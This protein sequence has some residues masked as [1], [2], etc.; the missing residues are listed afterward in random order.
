MPFK[1]L[2]TIHYNL[3]PASAGY[4]AS[5]AHLI[6]KG[7]NSPTVS[8]NPYAKRVE[9]R[10]AFEGAAHSNWKSVKIYTNHNGDYT[11]WYSSMDWTNPGNSTGKKGGG[12][13]HGHDRLFSKDLNQRFTVTIN[14]S[15]EH[16][17]THCFCADDVW[18]KDDD[19]GT[20]SVSL[21][22]D[23]LAIPQVMGFSVRYSAQGSNSN[24][25]TGGLLHRV[26]LLFVERSK[27]KGGADDNYKYKNNVI[28]L[29]PSKS[30]G[31]YQL[32]NNENNITD[33]WK[34]ISYIWSDS[35]WAT[36]QSKFNPND[37]T[38]SLLCIGVMIGGYFSPKMT[39]IVT[40]TMH[41]YKFNF[42]C[43]D[44]PYTLKSGTDWQYSTDKLLV[45]NSFNSG[46]LKDHCDNT[47]PSERGIVYYND[48]E[49]P[50]YHD[51]RG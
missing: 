4:H 50:G 39:S 30:I 42:I 25:T 22:R 15:Y 51:Y 38:K 45:A 24:S 10:S 11:R 16:Q 40:A 5:G 19:P 2:P 12:A 27:Y 13:V 21:N 36:L 46:L 3:K 41:L 8:V 26:G 20:T 49:M 32:S 43:G 7:M 33:D 29:E 18:D 9:M 48:Q 23:S 14:D 28:C 1:P 35:Q 6:D 37:D 47:Q 17:T 44:S 34:H 31:N